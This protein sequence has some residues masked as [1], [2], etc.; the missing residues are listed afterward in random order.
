M[1][2]TGSETTHDE[3]ELREQVQ[4]L[5]NDVDALFNHREQVMQPKVEEQ[6]STVED[7]RRQV[8][9]LEATVQR[10][11]AELDNLAGLADDEQS[12]PA[13]RVRDV[14]TLMINAA[15]AKAGDDPENGTVAWTYS[16]IV[17]QLE[18]NGHGRVYAAQAYNVM[19]DLDEHEGFAHVTNHGDEQ[20]LRVSYAALPAADRVNEINN[21]KGGSG[22]SD[23]AD[24]AAEHNHT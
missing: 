2:S 23:T 14:K 21:A 3:E 22:A 8:N 1:Q 18:A 24:T 16:Q 11:E 19:E 5:Q 13:A 7:L 10:L 12:T 20:V 9:D 15:D 17:D 4:A 6:Q